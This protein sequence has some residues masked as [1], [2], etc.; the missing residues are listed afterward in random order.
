[1]P[2]EMIIFYLRAK[3]DGVWDKGSVK[4]FHLIL[5]TIL[6]KFDKTATMDAPYFFA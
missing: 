5:S 4:Q 6:C 2:D 1:M 3:L